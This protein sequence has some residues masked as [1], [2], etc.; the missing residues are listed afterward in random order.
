VKCAL[1]IHYFSF[2]LYYPELVVGIEFR[3]GI[4][5]VTLELHA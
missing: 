4:F 5:R 2:T 1:N 3:E